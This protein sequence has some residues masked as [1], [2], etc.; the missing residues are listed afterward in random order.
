LLVLTTLLSARIS[1]DVA[2]AAAGELFAAG[3]G[4]PQ[5]MRQASWQDRVDAL[6]RGRYRRYDERTATMLDD[7][8]GQLLERWHGD[9]RRLRDKV[10]GRPA[11]IRELLTEF[12]GIGPTGADIFLREVQVVWPMFAPYAD[13][14]V[15]QAAKKVGLPPGAKELAEL[16]EQPDNLARLFSALVR[17]SRSPRAAEEIRQAAST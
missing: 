10:G 9:L 8:A 6:G 2:V 4:T 11:R 3:Y 12:K 1:A 17:V 15:I 5:R 16:A 14:R 13:R 7:A